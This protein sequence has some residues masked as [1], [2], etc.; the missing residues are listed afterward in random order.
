[1]P[2]NVGIQ[3]ASYF[4]R[5]YC[6]EFSIAL[7]R[8]T[9]WPIVVFNEV[10]D[11]DGEEFEN[12][13]HAAVKAP[14]GKYADARGFRSEAEMMSKM[15]GSL[16]NKVLRHSISPSSEYDLESIT[17]IFPEAIEQ[18][19]AFI[20]HNLKLW[21]LNKRK[22]SQ[23]WYCKIKTGQTILEDP[24][25]DFLTKALEI[26]GKIFLVFPF[27]DSEGLNYRL[28]D[29]KNNRTYVTVR[30]ETRP[31][32]M[33]VIDENDFTKGG[34]MRKVWLTDENNKLRILKS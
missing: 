10:V 19:E 24:E 20:Q 17:E 4:C 18:A 23:T 13:V 21:G 12:L 2:S 26:N 30:T 7:H 9:G 25:G 33:F 1:M 11:E 22:S 16:G 31:N 34:A 29:N 6:A 8:L 15:L 32:Q 3:N 28:V 14:N 5:G 27:T